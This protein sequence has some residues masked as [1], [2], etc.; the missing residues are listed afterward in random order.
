MAGLYDKIRKKK[1]ENLEALYMQDNAKS[2]AEAVAKFTNV[3]SKAAYGG[4]EA[5]ADPAAAVGGGNSIKQS[6]KSE[7]E[8]EEVDGVLMNKE[9][10]EPCGTD[11]LDDMTKSRDDINPDADED[12]GGLFGKKKGGTKVGNF[13]RSIVGKKSYEMMDATPFKNNG[14]DDD[15][16]ENDEGGDGGMGTSKGTVNIG[17]TLY[18]IGVTPGSQ[19][20]VEPVDGKCP[21]GMTLGSDGICVTETEVDPNAGKAPDD[22]WIKT[23]QEN[24]CLAPC[25]AQFGQCKEE[26]KGGKCPDGSA[27]GPDGKCTTG[28]P[29]DANLD[30]LT[31]EVENPAESSNNLTFGTQLLTNW[32]Q[33]LLEGSQGRRD[34]KD[35][36]EDKRGFTPKEQELYNQARKSLR[37]S[38]DLPGRADQ[39]ARQ[40]AIYNEMNRL[41]RMSEVDGKMVENPS[42]EGVD[43]RNIKRDFGGQGFEVGG[44]NMTVTEIARDIRT[45][46]LKYDSEDIQ[47]L[48]YEVKEKIRDIS[49]NQ[50]RTG[51]NQYSEKTSETVDQTGPGSFDDIIP[52][53]IKDKGPEA[54]KK[55]S[56]ENADKF[57]GGKSPFD[58][59]FATMKR[60]ANIKFG[61]GESIMKKKPNHFN[62]KR[63]KLNRPGY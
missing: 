42:G 33:N 7:V 47:N 35:M 15:N 37:K 19:N 45:G 57:P 11:K 23:C 20:T 21:P 48:P 51:T 29:A 31:E 9:T 17:G 61:L 6:A 38:G 14:G 43:N 46:R 16:L 58:R 36:R 12:G 60:P 22:E 25:H 32:G 55:W 1:K 63:G 40:R 4:G 39:V 18:N 2:M 30:K 26:P 53:E 62:M 54:V 34:S 50:G 24:P 13:L 52:Q 3:D 8:C 59:M 49:D 10:G 41:N 5:L 27:P 28:D 56:I 44:S